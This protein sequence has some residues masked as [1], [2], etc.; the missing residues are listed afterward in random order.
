MNEPRNPR[1]QEIIQLLQRWKQGDTPYPA[2]LQE[3]RRAAFL[4][5]LPLA[6]V[7]IQP[8]AG[9]AANPPMTLAMQVTLGVLSSFIVVMSVLVAN[10]IHRNWD[11]LT[12]NATATA[13]NMGLFGNPT[14]ASF[15]NFGAGGAT[16]TF[17]PTGTAITPTTTLTP[18]PAPLPQSTPQ[19]PTPT[20]P[21]HHYGQTKTPKPK[22][23]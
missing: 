16:P 3:K 9:T 7:A 8:T 23:K 17:A 15:S 2:S 20:I 6:P 11:I 12:G 1:D 13:T 22:H 4:A 21:G 10:S 14:D 18:S 19:P 5:T